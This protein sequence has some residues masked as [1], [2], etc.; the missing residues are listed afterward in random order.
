[1][2]T[3]QVN[4][5][6]PLTGSIIYV[7]GTLSA[8][9]GFGS[10]AE[11]HS[12]SLGKFTTLTAS[13]A[14]IDT[15]DVNVINSTTTTETT[16]EI[17]DKLIIA[18]SGATAA[19]SNEGGYQIGGYST[20]TYPPASMI[21]SGSALKFNI[22]GSTS[23]VMYLSGSGVVG[24]GTTT[25]TSTAGIA[26][27]IKIED[28]SSA[29]IVLNDT[30]GR[31]WNIWSADEKLYYWTTTDGNV[32]TLYDTKVGI[33]TTNPSTKL[34][35]AGSVTVSGLISGVT[36]PASAQDA[37]TKAYVDAQVE[38][39]SGWTDSGTSVYLTTSTDKVGIGTSSPDAQL[40]LYAEHPKLQFRSSAANGDSQIIFKSG[41]GSQVANIRCDVTS[42][43]LNHLG[44]SAGSS[45]DHLV[46]AVGGNVGVGTKTPSFKFS[47]TGSTSV[48]G[49]SHYTGSAYYRSGDKLNLGGTTTTIHGDGTNVII[50]GSALL[51]TGSV[52]FSDDTVITG[53]TIDAAVIGG[54]T[55][56]AGTFAALTSD[57]LTV[58][59]NTLYVDS[60]NNR[61]GVGTTSPGALLELYDEHPKLLIRS[62]AASGDGQII[63][64]SGDG[65]TMANFRCDVTNNIMNYFSINGSTNTD[66]LVI[67]SDGK[68]GIGT[69]DPE[70]ILHIKSSVSYKPE[71][72]IENANDDAIHSILRFYKST[73]DEAAGDDIGAIFFTG[74]DAADSD[75]DMAWILGAGSTVTA[76]AEEGVIHMGVASAGAAATSTLTLVGQGTANTTYAY[77]GDPA[78]SANTKVGIGI[79]N[80]ATALHVYDEHPTITMQSSDAGGDGAI[81]FK[82]LDGTQLAWIRCDATSNAL[83][84]LSINAGTGEN[85]LVVDSNGKVGIGTTVPAKALEINSSDGNNLRLTYNDADGSASNYADFTL[86]SGG[87]LTVNASGG[88]ITL[89]D[90]VVVSGTL[91]V[92]GTTTTVN[93]T[94]TTVDD[95]I[96]TLGGDTA[97]GS[98][99]NK[100]RGIEFRYYDS[101][102]KIG[103]FGYDDSAGEFTGFTAATNSSEVFSGTRMDANFGSI[104]GTSLTV[105][106]DIAFDTSTLFVDA[107][108]NKVGIGTTSP[109]A[110]LEIKAE[111]PKLFISSNAASGDGQIK[112]KS[113]DGSTMANIRC[114]V[115]SNLLNYFSI[116]AGASTDHLVVAV[117]GN[118]GIGTTTPDCALHVA[119]AAAFSGPSETFVT[120]GS[121]DTTPSVSTGNLFKT[122]ASGQTLTDFDDGVAGQTITVISTAAVVFD[123]TSSGLKGGSANITTASGDITVWTYDGTDWYLVQFMDVSANLSSPGASASVTALNNATANELVTVGSTTTEL[124]AESNLTFDGSTL[125]V[126]AHQLPG[127]DNTYDLGS[128][129][130]RYRNIYTGDLH[131]RNERGD[132]TILEEED[133]LCVINNK[134]GKKY[135]M[136]LK[137]IED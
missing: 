110:D 116:N 135:E 95:P 31:E 93:S 102:A 108:E 128:S 127:A 80:P 38:V 130:Y 117:G 100:D 60:S 64:R 75:A 125:T 84:Q 30:G 131:L 87:D 104:T 22:T 44:I 78:Q 81:K 132:W 50:S 11:T 43:A 106:G 61:V 133:F 86:S 57:S 126:T 112:F 119:G 134:T 115:S 35:V 5:L 121:S 63:F 118:V 28:A 136:M 26:K 137:P 34:H 48:S 69:T 32:M 109:G 107:S 76:G 53:G 70:E 12:G 83:N 77:F 7:T 94:T 19:S 101:S 49:S 3:L 67:K 85:H 91:T 122:H 17:S 103:F 98:D 14:K 1:M 37:A 114:D 105:S 74:K 45:E 59:T 68:I 6:T 97:P 111:H 55:T 123:V 27:F 36:D 58:D 10:G 33:G 113:G 20:T 4:N 89:D 79:V 13:Y 24:V 51:I 42:N 52:E 65:S 41:N 18:A 9:V 99:D 73:T 46:V 82:S 66:H 88:D 124:D 56:A 8:S 25:P 2:S 39:Q 54:S 21:F 40:E 71:V 15:L 62:N 90:N 92:N 72:I 23:P 96:F 29:G 16:L 120:F 47:V 129:S